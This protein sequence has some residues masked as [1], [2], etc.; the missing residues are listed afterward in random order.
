[1]S[2]ATL[3][4]RARRA[5]AARP[6]LTLDEQAKR[7]N[8][9]YLERWGDL[10]ELTDWRGSLGGLVIEER[11]AHELDPRELRRILNGDYCKLSDRE[12]DAIARR[13]ATLAL[14]PDGSYRMI[15]LVGGGALGQGAVYARNLPAP[16]TFS[17]DP[18]GFAAK[19]S[20]NRK[21]RPAVVH[22]GYATS[23]GD[24]IDAVGVVAKLYI[25]FEATYTSAAT[26]ATLTNHWPWNLAKS[27][28]VSANGINNLFS[29]QGLD[30]RML[31]RARAG[32]WFWDRESSFANP[33]ATNAGTIR[34]IYELPLAYDESLIGAVFAQTEETQL[35]VNVTTAAS[36]DLFSANPGTFSSATWKIVSEFYSIPTADSQAGRVLVLPDL[37]QLHGVVTRDDGFSAAGDVVS[38]LTR[39][40]GILLRAFQRID[41]TAPGNVDFGGS[42]LGGNITSHRFRYG[43]NVVPLD[44][45][46]YLAKYNNEQDY[47]DVLLPSV[48]AVSG[49]TA[50]VYVG[51]DFVVDSP[52]RDVVHLTGITEA[53]LI[54]S[55]ASSVSVNTGAQVHTVQE[56]MVAG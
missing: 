48:D 1:M 56:A 52:L 45:P 5:I 46:G 12:R 51:D 6:A 25:I 31:A 26:A 29:F 16:G 30:A 39:T 38:P 7:G 9:E 15:P 43:G 35:S 32:K 36:A 11:H 3:E 17:I 44:V 27:I 50:P 4:R 42:V 14:M 23:W 54:N 53:Q 28:I 22:P 37:T 47:G 24:R 19:T 40:G 8:R 20:R 13:E 2:T 18:V 33:T 34:L 10:G 21:I 41:N 55:V 49:A